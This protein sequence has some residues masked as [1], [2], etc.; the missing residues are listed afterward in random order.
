MQ[1]A[2]R[3]AAALNAPDSGG[4][5]L[6]FF[7][8]T[9]VTT[10]GEIVVANSYG[11]AYIPEGLQLPAP[12]HM[13]SADD[14]IPAAER[15]SWATYPVTA[16]QGWAAHRDAKLRAVIA[17]EQQLANSD[18]GAAKVALTPED[19]PDSGQMTGRSRLEVVNPDAAEELSATSDANLADLLP[20]QPVTIDP[21]DEPPPTSGE[22][23]PSRAMDLL[24]PSPTDAPPPPSADR[25]DA[26]WFEVIKPMTSNSDGRG[27]AHLRAFATYS[28]HAQEVAAAE[29]YGADEPTARRTA[30]ADWLYWQHLTGLL[31]Q[32]LPAD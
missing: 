7:W 10:D 13:A 11:L 19:I 3:I 24:P 2:R 27:A 18:P 26:L 32:A 12:V 16:V 9:G 23:D 8:V 15:A 14:T 4:S 31:E 25:R 30:V 22:I 6:G 5:D 28:A 17:T 21:P 29:A 20:P 1:L